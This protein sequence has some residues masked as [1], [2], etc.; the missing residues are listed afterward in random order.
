MRIGAKPNLPAALRLDVPPSS[1][2]RGNG[3]RKGWLSSL[4]FFENWI[5]DLE[6]LT[7]NPNFTIV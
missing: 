6:H 3:S 1:L 4:S 7:V 2:E 5:P